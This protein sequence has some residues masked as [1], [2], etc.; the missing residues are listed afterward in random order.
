MASIQESVATTI[1]TFHLSKKDSRKASESRLRQLRSQ[2][3]GAIV[4][5]FFGNTPEPT[6]SPAPASLLL[7]FSSRSRSSALGCSARHRSQISAP[8]VKIRSD[9]YVEAQDNIGIIMCEFDGERSRTPRPRMKKK[10]TRKKNKEKR[11]RRLGRHRSR[12]GRPLLPAQTFL[13]STDCGRSCKPCLP[14][15]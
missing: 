11:V 1:R 8:V 5:S 15:F 12:C 13:T 4:A 7:S 6:L 9:S 2:L 10:V 3:S 14:Q